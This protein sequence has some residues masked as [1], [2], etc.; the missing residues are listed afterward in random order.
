VCSSDLKERFFD[1][2]TNKVNFLKLRSSYGEVGSDEGIP[3]YAH[4][5]L[6][7]MAQNS[8]AAALYKSQNANPDL[9]WEKSASVGAAIEGRLF[10]RANFTIEYFD[11]QSR[12]LIFDVN[13]PLSAGAT[14]T[15]NAVSVITKNIGSVSNKGWELTFDVDVIRS[16]DFH[17]NFGANATFVKNKVVKLP[18]ENKENG[19]INGTKRI[20]EGHAINDFWL[21][22]FAGVD[23]M[24]GNALY[25]PDTVQYSLNAAASNAI[26]SQYLVT[27]NDQTYT[28][29]TTYAKK[30]WSGSTIPKVYGGFTTNIR[31]KNFTLGGLFTYALG[32]KVY[33][34]SYA[35][36]MSM[37]GT[38][39]AMHR[40][41]LKGW[42][43]A[44][45]DMIATSGN[46]IDPNGIPV[47]DFSRSDK[48]NATSS[49]FLQDGSY[50][51]VKNINLSYKFPRT[52]LSKIDM[53]SLSIGLTVDNLYTATRLQGMNPQQNFIGTNVNTFVTPR[54]VSFLLSAGL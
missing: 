29:F 20:M 4:L 45:K 41:L 34:N 23:Q 39:S 53:K 40:D 28:T 50:L 22:Q 18:D 47:V 54:V 7:S 3:Y 48:N 35:S 44:P 32:G 17:L 11:K 12:N 13:Q 9:Q 16:E 26:P 15:G 1:R 30:D 10:D 42:D 25:L 43:G 21:H 19:I 46:R 24:T 31:Y 51:V 52:L 38:V 33:D 8:S 14:A 2:L 27:I 37:N 6:Y 49:R 5:P 36:L